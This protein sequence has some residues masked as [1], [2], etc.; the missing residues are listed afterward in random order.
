MSLNANKSEDASILLTDLSSSVDTDT[1]LLNVLIIDDDDIDFTITNK[2]LSR[3]TSLA[4]NVTHVSKFKDIHHTFSSNAFDLVLIDYNLDHGTGLSIIQELG[5]RYGPCPFILVSGMPPAEI[6]QAAFDTGALGHLDKHTLS[7]E[8]LETVIRSALHTYSVE[9][10]LSETIESLDRANRS[11]AGLI[12]SLSHDLKTPLNA[13]IG[14]SDALR[15]GVLSE[16]ETDSKNGPAE[17]IFQAGQNL[18]HSINDLIKHSASE[19]LNEEP[20]LQAADLN[21][22]IAKAIDVIKPMASSM[23][24]TI[25]LD[26]SSSEATILCDAFAIQQMITNLLTNAI[27]YSYPGTHTDVSTRVDN[28]K[29]HMSVS[30]NGIGMSK[31]E[32]ENANKP[33]GRVSSNEKVAREGTGI[34]L[35]IVH[36][37]IERHDAVL[38]IE[39]SP[40]KG[41]SV[42]VQ[43]DSYFAG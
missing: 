11:R 38:T 15:S 30:D 3:I 34:G 26:L 14:Y 16:E 19:W 18:L 21:D 29:V 10:K 42:L 35:S 31:D 20:S 24:Q 6:R 4:F 41:T 17:I 28:G 22:I 36:D 32:L 12:S 27:K 13:I 2:N 43:F 7:P 1:E 8:L 39:S 23:K 33:F 5:G 37:I 40:Q 9:R 25:N